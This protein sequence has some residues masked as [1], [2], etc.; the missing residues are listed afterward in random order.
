MEAKKLI[1]HRVR[2]RAF[3]FTPRIEKEQVS[4]LS[5]ESFLDRYFRGSRLALLLNLLDDEQI[6]EDELREL[7]ETI[8]RFRRA[9]QPK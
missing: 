3:V 1:S 6:E 2:G 9:R 7:E 5:I 4:R 8:R